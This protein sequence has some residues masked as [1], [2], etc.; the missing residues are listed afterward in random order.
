MQTPE[1]YIQEKAW[2]QVEAYLDQKELN[3]E[4]QRRFTDGIKKSIGT[5]TLLDLH[6]AMMKKYGSPLCGTGRAVYVSKFAVFKVPLNEGGFRANDVECNLVYVPGIP[7]ARTRYVKPM[8]IEIL[9]MQR[10]EEVNYEQI[11]ER[12]GVVPSFVSAVYMGQVGY[13][14]KG[15]LVAY[16]YGDMM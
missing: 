6:L 7:L 12:E 2:S 9:A 14:R 1:Q 11:M 3:Q 16:D 8:L 13:T 4:E 5:G 10:V 15:K